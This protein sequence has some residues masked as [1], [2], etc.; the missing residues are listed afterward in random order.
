VYLV[1]GLTYLPRQDGNVNGTILG[2]ELYVSTDGVTWGTAVIAGTFASDTT[3]KTVRFIAKSGRYVKLVALS[4]INGQLWASAAEVNIFG[5][6]SATPLTFV[7]LPPVSA[8]DCWQVYAVASD[9]SESVGS[10]PFQIPSTIMGG[11]N[12]HRFFGK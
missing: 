7:A 11:G 8:A 3:A 5:M 6:M 2:Y 1:D 12:A 9:N 10:T 4:E